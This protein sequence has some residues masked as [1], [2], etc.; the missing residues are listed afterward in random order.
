MHQQLLPGRLDTV[1]RL[2]ELRI[3]EVEELDDEVALLDEEVLLDRLQVADEVPVL[4]QEL[5]QCCGGKSV[6]SSNDTLNFC[7]LHFKTDLSSPDNVL[8][9]EGNGVV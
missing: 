2:G 4:N 3:A 7:F 5:Q 9:L 1:N 6:S 8:G